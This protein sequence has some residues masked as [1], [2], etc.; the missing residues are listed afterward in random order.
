MLF[1][2]PTSSPLAP[3]DLGSAP[4]LGPCPC[5]PAFWSGKPGWR[6]QAA[7]SKQRLC[8]KRAFSN[9]QDF[10]QRQNSLIGSRPWLSPWRAPGI[11]VTV[12]QCQFRASDAPIAT[13]S[14]GHRS[15]TEPWASGHPRGRWQA[16]SLGGRKGDSEQRELMALFLPR[17]LRVLTPCLGGQ[18][19][20][21]DR[22]GNHGNHVAEAQFCR[23]CRRQEVLKTRTQ[24]Q[25]LPTVPRTLAAPGLA[26]TV[27]FDDGLRLP[28]APGQSWSSV[29][30][31][32]LAPGRDRWE[33]CRAAV[34]LSLSILFAP[35]FLLQ[36]KP[37][38]P[39][40]CA[41]RTAEDASG[42]PH[43]ST[44]CTN[45]VPPAGPAPPPTPG[46]ALSAAWVSPKQ[47]GLQAPFRKEQRHPLAGQVLPLCFTNPQPHRAQQNL[48]LSRWL[49]STPHNDGICALGLPFREVS[50]SACSPHA[51]PVAFQ[52]PAGGRDVCPHWLLWA[53]PAHTALGFQIAPLSTP[54][55]APSLGRCQPQKK[56]VLLA[57]SPHWTHL[58]PGVYAF[59]EQPSAALAVTLARH[60]GRPPP[61]AQEPAPQPLQIPF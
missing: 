57:C 53:T 16:R 2:L 1:R 6:Q 13:P 32:C 58:H 10:M 23:N 33:S 24:A 7:F 56:A 43:L 45:T 15:R 39:L 27:P 49:L 51:L 41:G 4:R 12:S 26:A 20:Q 54:P 3:W 38:E 59:T 11:Q 34:W 5:S 8:E 17:F 60:H 48:T 18:P 9:L 35:L 19:P 30:H 22:H 47:K 55:W 25:P 46:P 14:T 42:A 61:T 44:H 36:T 50:H 52:V 21:G 28:L 37:N 40:L 31:E 29:Q